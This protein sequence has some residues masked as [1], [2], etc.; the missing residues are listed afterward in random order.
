MP[1]CRRS[2]VK[3]WINLAVLA[4]GLALTTEIWA[5]D[6]DKVDPDQV[7]I[8]TPTESTSTC[9]GDPR[10]PV[11]AVETVMA[12]ALRLDMRL[13]GKV[14]ITDYALPDKLADLYRYRVL[15]VRII[16]P[17]DIT[18]EL[19]DVDWWKPGFARITIHE[20]DFRPSWCPNGCK[21]WYMAKPTET[22][23]HI[24]DWSVEGVDN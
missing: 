20:P 1:H 12:C 13:C 9:I 3:N 5:Q 8:I 18:L 2:K 17:G 7:R 6:A 11:C 15:S 16:R 4:A 23:W 24:L 14:G 10:T 19:Q 21:M 22:G